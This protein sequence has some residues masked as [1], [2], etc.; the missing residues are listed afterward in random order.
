M[1]MKHMGTSSP[2]GSVA[3]DGWFKVYQDGFKDGQFCTERIRANG[4]KMSFTIPK[5]LAGYG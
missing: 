3:G 2:S 4:N 5:D 1:Y